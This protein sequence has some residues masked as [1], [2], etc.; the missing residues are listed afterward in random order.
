MQFNGGKVKRLIMWMLHPA[1]TVIVV[2]G[3]LYLLERATTRST[4]RALILAQL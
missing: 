1:E 3:R 2:V 4:R